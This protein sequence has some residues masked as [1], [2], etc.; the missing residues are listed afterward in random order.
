MIP[1]FEQPTLPLGPVTLHA[2]GALVGGALLAGSALTVRRCR[3]SGLDPELGGDLAIYALVAGFVAAH[4]YAT[5]AYFP[6]DVLRNP[7]LL[8]KIWENISSFGGF[9]GGLFGIW[10]FFKMRAPGLAREEKWKYLDAVVFV[11]PFAWAIGRLACT[12]AHDHPG[13]VTTFPLGVSLATPEAREYIASY[14]ASAGRLAELPRPAQLERMAFHDLGWYEFLYTLFVIVPAFLV[15]DRKP[16][17]AGFYAIAFLFLYVPARFALD[18]LRLADARY[19]GL[20]PAQYAG[21]AGLAGA[22]VAASV[23]RRNRQERGAT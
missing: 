4:L 18:F 1:Y 17:R 7:I 8:F 9:V 6:Q 16:R 20:T 11:L 15:L 2:F 10:L 23:R 12:V 5:L 21:I 13:T 3:K 19:L 14:Y 22:G